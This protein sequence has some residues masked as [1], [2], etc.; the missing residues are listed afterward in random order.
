MYPF[1]TIIKTYLFNHVFVFNIQIHKRD[2]ELGFDLSD[3]DSLLMSNDYRP[4]HDPHLK[5]HL[6][7]PQMRKRLRAGNFITRD[8]KVLCSLKEYNEYRQYLRRINLMLERNKMVC[9][10]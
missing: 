4:L 5:Q 3:P 10:L 1:L 8:G 6:S 9:T 7:A 2:P